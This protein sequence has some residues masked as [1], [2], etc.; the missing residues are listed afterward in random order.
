MGLM[1]TD[2]QPGADFNRVPKCVFISINHL[3]DAN[4]HFLQR[5]DTTGLVYLANVNCR[6]VLLLISPESGEL[7]ISDYCFHELLAQRV[8]M[9]I[10][11]QWIAS[12]FEV[13]L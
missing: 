3:Q 9:S 2:S 11:H 7:T 12:T 13:I 10:A 4:W 8:G 5:W 1:F 6:N